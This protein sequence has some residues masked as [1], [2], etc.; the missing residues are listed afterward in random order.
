MSTTLGTEAASITT[1]ERTYCVERQTPRTG[2]K[3]YR[4]LVHR[5]I[6]K[7]LADGTVIGVTTI[8]DAVNEPVSKVML[9]VCTRDYLAACQ[10]AKV[11]A[12]L[13]AAEVAWYDALVAEARAEKE[14][15]AA[16]ED[17]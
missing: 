3:D 5:E 7:T 6:V 1:T 11:P 4:L 15:A 12:D 10:R 8:P 9:R 2:Q 16:Q 14:Q 13:L 17:G